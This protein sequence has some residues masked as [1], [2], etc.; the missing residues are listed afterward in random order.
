LFVKIFADPSCA[1]LS[2]ICFAV[3]LHG[4]VIHGFLLAALPLFWAFP[5]LGGPAFNGESWAPYRALPAVGGSGPSQNS[6]IESAHELTAKASCLQLQ[7]E[8]GPIR[9][10][11]KPDSPL[12]R[13]FS[14]QQAG[15]YFGMDQYSGNTC[16]QLTALGWLHLAE[17]SLKRSKNTVDKGKQAEQQRQ[18][19]IALASAMRA[20]ASKVN[21][22]ESKPVG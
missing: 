19:G 6:Q 8:P 16:V 21:A 20:L 15:D 3:A 13:L 10:S 18:A 1:C 22:V 12:F 11:E 7:Y 4:F 2:T 9:Q 5:E 14:N 17:E